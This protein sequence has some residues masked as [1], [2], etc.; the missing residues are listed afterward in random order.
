MRVESV[1]EHSRHPKP[2]GVDIFGVSQS[3]KFVRFVTIFGCRE[4]L[5][6]DV[7]SGISTRCHHSSGSGIGTKLDHG[8]IAVRVRRRLQRL[9]LAFC[10]E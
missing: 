8:E 9:F 4:W 6:N 5:V 7:K 3:N 10:D 1:I 2:S